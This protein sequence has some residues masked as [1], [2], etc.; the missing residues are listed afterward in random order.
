MHGMLARCR[1]VQLICSFII[2]VYSSGISCI[3]SAFYF[4]DTIR[5]NACSTILY[6]SFH[7]SMIVVITVFFDKPDRW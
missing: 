7:A 1:D 6:T 4:S 5:P 3:V 2:A